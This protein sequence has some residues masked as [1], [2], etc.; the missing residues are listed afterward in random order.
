MGGFLLS[1][2]VDSIVAVRTEIY[3]CIVF[4]IIP[5]E[6]VSETLVHGEFYSASALIFL[7]RELDLREKSPMRAGCREK[8]VTMQ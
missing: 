5:K 7:V 8:R 6:E 1:P 3:G 4:E 2:H